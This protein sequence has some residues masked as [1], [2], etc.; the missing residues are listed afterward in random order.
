V[1]PDNVVSFRRP[2]SPP[3]VENFALDVIKSVATVMQTLSHIA[4]QIDRW[5]IDKSRKEGMLIATRSIA[6]QACALQLSAVE[7]G[8]ETDAFR[9][10]IIGAM[11]LIRDRDPASSISSPS[12]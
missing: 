5:P 10:E 7:R 12:S 3:V 1:P 4:L 8:P 2:A 9:A 11:A 6:L